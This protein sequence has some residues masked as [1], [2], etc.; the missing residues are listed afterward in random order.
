MIRRNKSSGKYFWKGFLWSLGA[1]FL[2][3]VTS[4]KPQIPE[5]SQAGVGGT[6]AETKQ[7]PT[8]DRGPTRGE[9]TEP[10]SQVFAV[11]TTKAVAGELINYL[12]LNGDVLAR[13]TVDIFPDIGGK[14]SKLFI[15]VGDRIEKDQVI[16]EIDPS[17]PGMVFV[18]S[19]VKAPIS[20]TVTSIPVYV[21]S[22]V[23]Q[24]MPIAR[25]TTKENLEIRTEVP[26]RFIG[27]VQPG[28]EAFVSFVAFPG[29][30]FRGT[31]TELSPLVDPLSRTLEVR[32]RL[33]RQDTRIRPGMYAALRLITERKR[34]VV[35]VPVDALVR[36]FGGSFIFVV[37]D[38]P[39]AS[40]GKRVERREVVPGI[41]IDEK[42]EILKGL[43][44]GEDIV[45]MGQSLLEEK[46]VV[47]VVGEV[48]PLP[49]ADTIP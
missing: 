41:Q 11:T 49:V 39:S 7:G 18:P 12:E 9:A 29:E 16:A 43:R 34:G 4:C 35:K 20:G 10:V 30:V 13:S 33:N 48:P 1:L 25:L 40:T 27:S 17:R 26:E 32:I 38:D 14:V 2:V 42:V 3:I 44:P 31:V 21:G 15:N 46:S 24:A 6:S 23:S 8:P 36:R 37:K 22:T 47:R 19:P 5:G 45:V 28:L